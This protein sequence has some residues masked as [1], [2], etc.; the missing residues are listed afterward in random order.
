MQKYAFY[1][2]MFAPTVLRVGMVGIVIWFGSQELLH[3][4]MWQGY[5]PESVVTMSHLNANIL[6]HI[7][8]I[9]EVIFGLALL[10][11]I[12]TRF[13]AFLLTIHMFDIAYVVGY[14]PMGMR[15][16]G[17]SIALL[18]VFMQGPSPLSVDMFKKN[19]EEESPSLEV[20]N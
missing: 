1:L 2:K 14:S 17:L 13:V 19:S 12:Q 11:G 20:L 10:L 5:I 3:P 8:G 4:L 16:L 9:F 18:S 6:V 7:N 15:D